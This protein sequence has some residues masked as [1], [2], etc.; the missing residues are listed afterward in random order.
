MV[1]GDVV[2]FGSVGND[3]IEFGTSAVAVDKQLP[4]SVAHGEIGAAVAALR[5]AEGFVVAA[6]FPKER[7]GSR[8]G[9]AKE[10]R[11]LIFAVEGGVGGWRSAGQCA[12]RGKQIDG[13]E[14]R[15]VIGAA[16]GRMAGPAGDEGKAYPAF[17]EAELA[18]A[19]ASGTLA[20]KG[21][22]RA[23]VAGKDDER[24]AVDAEVAE[25]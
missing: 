6:I 18:A 16:G 4:V 15:R 10:G 17:V 8:L 13:T 11:G 24:F 21:R 20:L 22:Q 19:E 25:A 3:V 9:L 23:V 1:G 12:E 7:A 5:I 2:R 14:N